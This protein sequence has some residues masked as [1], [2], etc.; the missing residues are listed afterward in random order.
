M[1]RKNL[2]LGLT[3]MLGAVLVYL[4]L[5]SRQ[6]EKEIRERPT[7][8]IKSSKLSRTRV[9]SPADLKI[10]DSSMELAEPEAGAATGGNP[11]LTARH[12]LMIRN[13]GSVRYHNPLLK[14]SYLD[15]SEKILETRTHTAAGDISPGTTHSFT[16]FVL[17]DI[18]PNTARCKL[19]I[20]YSDITTA[21]SRETPQ[22][23]Q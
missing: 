18:P 1:F 23:P 13:G 22:A 4:V 3:V 17:D 15:G 9:I 6:E 10:T 21:L 14:I 19:R 5:Q 12:R 20:L 8:I 2:F 16:Q 7:E 11:G